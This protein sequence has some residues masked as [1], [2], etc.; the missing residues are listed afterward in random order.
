[1]KSSWVFKIVKFDEDGIKEV[2]MGNWVT[3]IPAS[4][5]CRYFEDNGWTV[6]YLYQTNAAV[7]GVYEDEPP[8]YSYKSCLAF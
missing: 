5:I 4:D 2:K 8:I 3:A 1:M 6:V 7:A